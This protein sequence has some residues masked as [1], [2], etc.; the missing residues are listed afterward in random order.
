LLQHAWAEIE[1]DLGYKSKNSLPK[2]TRRQF[3]RLAGLLELA[4]EQFRQLRDAHRA[5]SE[6]VHTKIDASDM[7]L[8]LDQLTVQSFLETNPTALE[9]DRMLADKLHT[10]TIEYHSEY[11]W[12]QTTKLMR[13]GA[14]TVQDLAED[15]AA[16]RDLIDAFSDRWIT[17]SKNH[18]FVSAGICLFYLS[19]L[20]M[21]RL[22]R[23]ELDSLLKELNQRDRGILSSKESR[24]RLME[25][26]K[27]IL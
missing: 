14:E 2:A 27:M 9:I 3:Y 18:K 26:G 7:D 6:E 5:Y 8:P 23:D 20:K 13:L 4:D 10:N 24:D 1:H 15:L 19:L 21:S 17:E 12:R 22:S 16:N 25:I 11:A